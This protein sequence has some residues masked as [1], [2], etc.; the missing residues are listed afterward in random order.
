M[1]RSPHNHV[2]GIP[3]LVCLSPLAFLATDYLA[4]LAS[5]IGLHFPTLSL[6]IALILENV[7]TRNLS[8]RVLS[9]SVLSLS[10]TLSQLFYLTLII[11]H[12]PTASSV[13]LIQTKI[14]IVWIAKSHLCDDG[15][16]WQRCNA[17]LTDGLAKMTLSH[18]KFGPLVKFGRLG[19]SYGHKI[20]S[21]GFY[22]FG[23]PD[24]V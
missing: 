22:L 21:F 13:N 2:L 14:V 5:S 3:L 7:Y 8:N 6:G 9:A 12:D 24:S 17:E 4:S 10:T 1:P 15:G 23:R 20:R 16:G 19:R 18:L 11:V